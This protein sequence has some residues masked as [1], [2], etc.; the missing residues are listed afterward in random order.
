MLKLIVLGFTVMAL[1]ACGQG[2]PAG[3][4]RGATF[5]NVCQE[6]RDTTD[7]SNINNCN[8]DNDNSVTEAPPEAP[9]G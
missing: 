9:A 2:D 3:P 8:K 6:S 4:A 5:L 1:S 7:I